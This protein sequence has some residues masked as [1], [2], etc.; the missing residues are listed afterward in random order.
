MNKES[1]IK[2]KVLTKIGHGDVR[3]HSH[4]YFVVRVVIVAAFTIIALVLSV[5]VLSFAIFSIHESGEQFLLG[6]GKE[7]MITFFSLFP[8]TI[9]FMD[10][11]LFALIEWLLRRFKF[12]YRIPVLRALFGIVVFAI[13]GGIIVYLTPLHLTLL[14]L[15]EQNELPILGEWYEEI[16]A[17]HADQG[18]FRGTIGSIQGNEFVIFHNDLDHDVDDGT[19]TVII[20]NGFDILT[21]RVGERVYVAGTPIQPGVIQAY[22]IQPLSRNM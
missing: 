1:D 21:L 15:A 7:G 3:K 17:S 22:G 5:F 11:V 9:L 2:E 10:I 12:G 18:V 14:R 16:Y 19:W 8:W 6:F 20:P 4:A 13:I